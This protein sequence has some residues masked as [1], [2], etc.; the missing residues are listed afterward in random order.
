MAKSALAKVAAVEVE[1]ATRKSPAVGRGI[2]PFALRFAEKVETK[3]AP[4]S[5]RFEIFD[6]PTTV[7]HTDGG[8][9]DAHTDES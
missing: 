8:R 5:D 2:R 1:Q 3:P 4:K 6:D 9:E 7:E